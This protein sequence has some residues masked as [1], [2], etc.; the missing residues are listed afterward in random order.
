MTNTITLKNG[1]RIVY[2]HVPSIRSC[3]LGIWVESGSRHEPEELSGISHFIEH[4][5]FKV[6]DKMNAAQL[7]EAF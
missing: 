1:V 6:T 5:M 7:A 3:A 4:M 2:E